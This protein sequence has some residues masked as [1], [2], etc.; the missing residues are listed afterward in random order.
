MCIYRAY[1]PSFIFRQADITLQCLEEPLESCSGIPRYLVALVTD[2]IRLTSDLICHHG[3]CDLD[4]AGQC[5]HD[6]ME[7]LDFPINILQQSPVVCRY[8]KSHISLFCKACVKRPLKID[9]TKI[10]MTNGTL[11]KVKV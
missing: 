3:S 6:A 2:E 8:D 4:V 10:L 11:M 1:W 7:T 9:K 5:L